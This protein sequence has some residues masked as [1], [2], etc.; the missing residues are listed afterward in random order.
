[1][2]RKLL[3][4]L[5]LILSFT[6]VVSLFMV[7]QTQKQYTQGRS[8]YEEAAMVVKLPELTAVPL[9]EEP[10]EPEEPAVEIEEEDREDVVVVHDR[11]LVLLAEM[12]LDELRQENPDVLGWISIPETVLSY[13]V[14]QGE[15]ND[16]YLNHTWQKDSSIVGS[17][18]MDFRCS[19]DMTDFNTIIYGHRM[20]NGSM[21]ASLKYYSDQEHWRTHP[22]I[23]LVNTE[24]A[25]RYDIFSA[26]EASVDGPV[27]DFNSWDA[28]G[29]QALIDSSIELS[30][31]ETGIVPTADDQILTLTTCTGRGY[32]TRWIVQGVLAEFF[33]GTKDANT[34]I[35]IVE[36]R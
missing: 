3:R 24:G 21:F 30:V 22:S 35:D 34:G 6:L 16:F 14:L 11:N 31:I 32:S 23:Y 20:R 15:D 17:I 33:A 8:A 19:A 36:N 26:Y 27:Y 28:E 13:P 29:R 9:P 2:K 12:N 18:F 10:E 1:M 7:F 4:V 5:K 25:Y